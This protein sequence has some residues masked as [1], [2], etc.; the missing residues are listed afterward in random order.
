MYYAVKLPLAG[1][2]AWFTLC[3]VDDVAELMAVI[4]I[5]TKPETNKYSEVKIDVLP[6]NKPQ[7]EYSQTS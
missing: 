1:G 6:G 4:E 7:R 2:E 5:I 3:E